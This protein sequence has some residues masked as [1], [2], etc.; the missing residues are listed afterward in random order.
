MSK[1]SNTNS[2]KK[3]TKKARSSEEKETQTTTTPPVDTTQPKE[4]SYALMNASERAADVSK[5][6]SHCW[7]KHKGDKKCRCAYMPGQRTKQRCKKSKGKKVPARSFEEEKETQ[8]T[9]MSSADVI[10]KFEGFNETKPS[11][12]RQH[13]KRQHKKYGQLTKPSVGIKA[14][15]CLSE[16]KPPPTLEQLKQQLEHD[17]AEAAFLKFLG[18]NDEKS[19]ERAKNLLDFLE[20]HNA[21]YGNHV[22]EQ[23]VLGCLAAILSMPEDDEDRALI[24]VAF[25][26]KVGKILERLQTIAKVKKGM[27][28]VLEDSKSIGDE[29]EDPEANFEAP[30]NC[31]RCGK[32]IFKEDVHRC[33]VCEEECCWDCRDGFDRCTKCQ[34]EEEDE[35]ESNEESSQ[36]G[37]KEEP[38][39]TC[40]NP[41]CRREHAFEAHLCEDCDET[42]CVD[43]I[44]GATCHRCSKKQ[45]SKA[46]SGS[47]FSEE[48]EESVD[49]RDWKLRPVKNSL[50]LTVYVNEPPSV[51]NGKVKR[52][53]QLRFT[54]DPPRERKKKQ[55]SKGKDKEKK[56]SCEF[57]HQVIASSESRLFCVE[58]DMSLCKS[59]HG[60]TETTE[61]IRCHN[62]KMGA[63]KKVRE[64]ISC[65]AVYTK[66]SE[67]QRSNLVEEA[68]KYENHYDNMMKCGHCN[69]Y[70]CAFRKSEWADND[71]GGVDHDLGSICYNCCMNMSSEK[72]E[73][74]EDDEDSEGNEPDTK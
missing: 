34:S 27:S 13:G 15:A 11:R 51:Y 55:E 56:R 37:D 25:T 63:N 24:M 38:Y 70:Y 52:D 42:Y 10:K 44:D 47:S 71:C 30:F 69:G 73:S 49:K 57:C 18:D 21:K 17:T 2:S 6:P 32:G 72:E 19:K 48:S 3:P 41:T 45:E 35:K 64:C 33:K 28:K 5:H 65:N 9:T 46:S 39:H 60:S 62:W 26:R 61:C 16:V 14:P 58:C 53:Y 22:F 43:C 20:V 59:C 8:T 1:R 66:R 23:N 12:N 54:A 4:T 40:S 68:R 74:D 36:N 7:C 29:D 31:S 67:D 50:G